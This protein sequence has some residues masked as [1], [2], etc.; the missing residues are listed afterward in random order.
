[1]Q[2]MR[3]ALATLLKLYDFKPI[4]EEMKDAEQVRQYFTLQV[5]KNSFKCL[6]KRR[7]A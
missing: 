7:S 3:L 6:L 5:K 4:P 1:M 2:E